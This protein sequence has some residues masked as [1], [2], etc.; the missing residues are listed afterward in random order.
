MCGTIS[1]FFRMA[2]LSAA[3]WMSMPAPDNN[4]LHIFSF[5]LTVFDYTSNGEENIRQAPAVVW[6]CRQR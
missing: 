6:R 3:D 1:I 5:H 4:F 2:T